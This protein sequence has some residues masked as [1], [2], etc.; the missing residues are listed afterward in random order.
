MAVFRSLNPDK[1]PD[2]ASKQMRESFFNLDIAIFHFLVI[3]ET[4]DIRSESG[5][6]LLN[7][8]LNKIERIFRALNAKVSLEFFRPLIQNPTAGLK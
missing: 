2:N 8:S 7:S 5:I 6:F 1:I 3:T 4:A